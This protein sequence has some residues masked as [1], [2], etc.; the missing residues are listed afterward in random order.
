MYFE[1]I[2]I[3]GLLAIGWGVWMQHQRIDDL[4]FMMGY[5]LTEIGATG[6]G[7]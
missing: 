1:I 7:D 3:V 4:E 6:E 2:N 5:V